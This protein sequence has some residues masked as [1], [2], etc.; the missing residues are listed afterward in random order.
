M[1]LFWGVGCVT[2]SRR[3]LSIEYLH[4][5]ADELRACEEDATVDEEVKARLYRTRRHYVAVG[6]RYGL[7]D[8]DI[9]AALGVSTDDVFLI[10]HEIEGSRR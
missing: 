5:I 4:R 10:E 2:R 3:L 9:A 6:R 8:Y 7:D 1:V